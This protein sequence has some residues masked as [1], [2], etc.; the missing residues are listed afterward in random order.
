MRFI[1]E[2][3]DECRR[4]ITFGINYVKIHSPCIF[5]IYEPLK[6][7]LPL[8]RYRKIYEFNVMDVDERSKKKERE[9]ERERVERKGRHKYKTIYR[10]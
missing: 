8:R 9:R 5:Q 4:S 7:T 6:I 2:Y 1:R 10:E 3:V